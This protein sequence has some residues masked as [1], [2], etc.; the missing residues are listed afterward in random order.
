MTEKGTYKEILDAIR[1]KRAK[2]LIVS[3]DVQLSS[4]M[5]YINLAKDNGLE[6]TLVDGDDYTGDIGLV[7]VSDTAVDEENIFV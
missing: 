7:V 3:N 2:R 1:D 5:D 6:F 4:A